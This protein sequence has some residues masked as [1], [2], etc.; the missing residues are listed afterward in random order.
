MTS[1]KAASPLTSRINAEVLA[2]LPFS[3][4]TDFENA[5][6]GLIVAASGQIKADAGHVAWDFDR[7]AFLDGDA[8][9]S[10]NPS[11]WRQG[12]LNAIAGIFEVAEGIYQARGFDLRSRA[13]CAPTPAGSSSI[14]WS[15]SRRCGPRSTGA[16]ACRR[17]AGRGGDPHP[18]PRRPL[19][20]RPGRGQRRGPRGGPGADHRPGRLPRGVG[21]REH[22]P[23]QRHVPA[24]LVH[25]RQPRGHGPAGGRGRRA[26]PAD[27][28]RGGHPAAADGHRVRDRAG[29]D[30][31]RAADRLPAHARGRGAGRALLLPPGAPGPVHERDRVAH[32]PQRLHAPRREDPRRAGLVEPHQ[33]GDPPV[34]RR[35]RRRVRV[36]PLADLGQ[37]RGRSAS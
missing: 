3:D 35:H 4:E 24:G 2:G 13:S 6:R 7:W 20:R 34:R 21:Q 23:G 5:R 22:P 8:P 12:Q 27:R 14:P 19:R 31:R 36:A 33:R 29:D 11:L 25:V 9:P 26:R 16:H 30:D 1:P 32:P 10:A 37:R 17:P 15:P 28:R 18:Q